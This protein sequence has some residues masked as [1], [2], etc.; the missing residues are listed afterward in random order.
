MLQE[1]PTQIQPRSSSTRDNQESPL[2]DG[3]SSNKSDAEASRILIDLANQD[4]SNNLMMIDNK[5]KRRASTHGVRKASLPIKT[6]T[7]FHLQK[8]R[9]QPDPIMLLAA[10]AAVIDEGKYKGRL[11]ERREIRLQNRNTAAKRKSLPYVSNDDS[12]SRS[13]TSLSRRHSDKRYPYKRSSISTQRESSDT[14]IPSV[15]SNKT[16]DEEYIKRNESQSE[17]TH[18]FSWQYLSMKQNPRIKRNAMHAY[19]AYMIYTDIAHE[20]RPRDNNAKFAYITNGTPISQNNNTHINNNTNTTNNKTTTTT[21][22]NIDSKSES[23]RYKSE[24]SSTDSY[25]GITPMQVHNTND[26]YPASY[27]QSYRLPPSPRQRHDPPPA[28]ETIIGRPLTDFLFEHRQSN[29]N[30]YTPPK[31][32]DASSGSRVSTFYDYE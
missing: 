2:E 16:L 31:F 9:I 13:S 3:I 30:T 24:E 29:G 27:M 1:Y 6:D 4:I 32:N 5:F 19:I 21:T 17:T 7:N 14:W 18:A 25:N 15:L 12:D 8:E 10:A 28:T 23:T 22:T 11:Y 20:Q 26:W